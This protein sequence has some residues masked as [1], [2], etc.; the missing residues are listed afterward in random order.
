MKDPIQLKLFVVFFYSILINDYFKFKEKI[1][2]ILL[3]I[4]TF[5]IMLNVSNFV[6]IRYLGQFVQPVSYL[7]KT[8][9]QKKNYKID[10]YYK[11]FNNNIYNR[12]YKSGFEV[13]K[14]YPIFWSRK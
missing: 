8:D 6:K 5:I 3:L 10:A 13:F 12:L 1:F 2:S 7:F 9:E 4:L 11:D 14:E